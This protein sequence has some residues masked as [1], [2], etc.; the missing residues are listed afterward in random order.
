MA[1]SE[2]ETVKINTD[3]GVSLQFAQTSFL[4]STGLSV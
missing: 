3:M 1:A 4:Q 2:E